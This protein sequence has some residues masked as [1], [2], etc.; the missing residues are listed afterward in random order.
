MPWRLAVHSSVCSGAAGR[1]LA[2]WLHM[3][4]YFKV[5]SAV[6]KLCSIEHQAEFHVFTSRRIE[7]GRMSQALLLRS[8]NGWHAA[9][10]PCLNLQTCSVHRKS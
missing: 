2:S 9:R 3:V 8:M 4:R 7:A 1:A 6:D 5:Q 10:L